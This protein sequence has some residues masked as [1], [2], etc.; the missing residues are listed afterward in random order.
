MIAPSKRAFNSRQPRSFLCFMNLVIVFFLYNYKCVLTG[1]F[2]KRT[3]AGSG[4]PSV[5]KHGC[6]QDVPLLR[7]PSLG[8]II[9]SS[10]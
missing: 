1:W 6:I 10:Y 3:F 5:W 9:I 2:C 4:P 8:G 7:A